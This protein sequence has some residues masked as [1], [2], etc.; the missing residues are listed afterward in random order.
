MLES[1]VLFWSDA[2]PNP[3]PL[4]PVFCPNLSLSNPLYGPGFPVNRVQTLTTNDV[5]HVG[6]VM[7]ERCYQRREREEKWVNGSGVVGPTLS[8]GQRSTCFGIAW[9]R[10]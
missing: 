9:S 10:L 7:K 5:S 1:R 2:H 6:G 3:N 8:I 4:E